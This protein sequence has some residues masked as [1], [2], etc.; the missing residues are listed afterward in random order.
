MLE[1]QDKF[2]DVHEYFVSLGYHAVQ[3]TDKFWSG[4]WSD[5]I[6]EQ[7]PMRAVK[8]VGGLIGGRG[9]TQGTRDQWAL[10]AHQYASLHKSL[11]ELSSTRNTSS[12]QHVDLSQS[13][14]SRDIEDT[15]NISLAERAQ[16]IQLM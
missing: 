14:K 4:L 7:A 10:T 13:R 5:L 9:F 6:I 1:L 8:S 15:E 12:E 2:H 16:S 3:C 11:T